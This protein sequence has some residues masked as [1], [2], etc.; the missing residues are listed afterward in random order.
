[1]TRNAKSA[2]TRPSAG[3]S[4]PAAP[5]A[6]LLPY[7]KAWANDRSR[8]KFGLMSR[9][10]GKDFA[11]GFEGVRDCVEAELA[12]TK[13]DWLI[14][15]PSER[16]SLE[17]LAKWRAWAESFNVALEG[18]EVVREGGSESL[19]KAGT[20]VFPGGSRVI[21]VPGKPD[22]VRGYSANVLLTEFAFFEQPDATWRAILPSI[23]NSL[24][25]GVKKVRLITTPNGI[26]NKAHDIWSKNFT[27]G[28]GGNR[29]TEKQRV[30]RGEDRSQN[31]E[32][33]S[34]AGE[35]CTEANEGN[36]GNEGLGPLSSVLSPPCGERRNAAG[37]LGSLA[38]S[39]A[40]VKNSG[41][42][43]ACHFVDIYRAVRDGLPVDV[44]ELKEALDDP[45]GWAQEFE[46]QFLD[47]QS[48]LLPYELLATCESLE[49]TVAVAA[50]FWLSRPAFP[51]VMG[52]DF[53]RHRDLSVA[54]TLAQLGD[55]QQTV[56]VLELDRMS[57]PAQ[58]ELFRPRIRQARRVCLDYTGAGI[59]LGDY[60]VKEFGEWSPGQHRFGK[61]ELCAFSSGLKVEIFSKLRMAFEKRALRV[62][63]SRMI[64]E[65]LH[66]INRVTTPGGQVTYRAAHT[67]DGHADR[68]TA[69]ALAVRAG[70][71]GV[72]A[73]PVR[74]QR[75]VVREGAGN[76]GMGRVD[77]KVWM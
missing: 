63:V 54:W 11:S 47:T 13:V 24:R 60:L 28:N 50:E 64:R 15:A 23:T 72:A 17:S 18:Q 37:N 35:N 6:E 1:M 51:L 58:V 8:W 73:G 3:R 20:I 19:L 62:P 30:E 31:S 26:G 22:T 61:I 53:G 74:V 25:G 9:Q 59:G 34:K 14:A 65:D 76:L 36:E 52:I 4:R 40:A 57:T 49:A 2:K 41:A 68:C 44:D 67:P 46:C 43:W 16:Q 70:A 10:V 29:E 42:V 48:V 77:G 56:E 5:G 21:A 38:P 66:L 32:D 69:L 33:R 39:L 75:V 27:G 55:V 7:Q 45:D 12:G 71:D